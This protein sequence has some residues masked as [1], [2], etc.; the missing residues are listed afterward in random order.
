VKELTPEEFRKQ[1][2]AEWAHLER[3]SGQTD[4]R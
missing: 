4:C 1:V 3:R 2:D